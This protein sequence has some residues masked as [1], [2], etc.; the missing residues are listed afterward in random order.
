MCMGTFH[1][2]LRAWQ[3]RTSAVQLVGIRR[4]VFSKHMYFFSLKSVGF[5]LSAFLVSIITKTLKFNAFVLI[6]TGI[7]TKARKIGIRWVTNLISHFWLILQ[8][9]A[10]WRLDCNSINCLFFIFLHGFIYSVYTCFFI[11]ILAQGFQ[12]ILYWYSMYAKMGPS[13]NP[14][15]LM[16]FV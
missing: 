10:G 12:G 8:V 4:G 2:L 11:F 7:T 15:C 3:R 6:V 16:K 5:F 13:K 1:W 14:S 9:T